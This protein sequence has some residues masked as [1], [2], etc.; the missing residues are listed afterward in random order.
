M[1]Q[2]SRPGGSRPSNYRAWIAGGALGIGL[3]SACFV[4]YDLWRPNH[5]VGDMY[6]LEVV[7]RLVPLLAACIVF[8]VAALVL[9]IGWRKTG[10]VSWPR[11]L[12]VMLAAGALFAIAIVTARSRYVWAQRKTYPDKTV[13]ELLRLATENEDQ[14]AIDALGRK[15]DPAAVPGLRRILLD[16]TAE[17]GALRVSAAWA[18]CHIGTPDARGALEEAEAGN[19]PAYLQDAIRYA[20]DQMPFYEALPL[21]QPLPHEAD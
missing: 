11:L 5:F 7:V 9:G 3:L 18:L 6:G 20:L 12:A 2:A 4:F 17:L 8:A 21:G 13:A 1:S 14:F 10:R 19:P 16:Q 15:R